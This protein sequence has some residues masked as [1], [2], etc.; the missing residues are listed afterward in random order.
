[1]EDGICMCV[2]FWY[3]GCC[4]SKYPF[5]RKVIF[6]MSF[7]VRLGGRGRYVFGCKFK[8]CV[9][10]KVG[11]EASLRVVFSVFVWVKCLWGIINVLVCDVCGRG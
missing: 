5:V 2:V 3:V 4:F 1:M 9:V 6:S 11:F 8:C 7:M 10:M